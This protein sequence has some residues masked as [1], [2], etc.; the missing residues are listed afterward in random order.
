MERGKEG[1]RQ[2]FKVS[3]SLLLVM[4]LNEHEAGEIRR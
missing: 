2:Q 3:V 1:K 4:S